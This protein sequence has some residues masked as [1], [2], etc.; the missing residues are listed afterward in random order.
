[1]NLKNWLTLT[2]RV[3]DFNLVALQPDLIAK[4]RELTAA[5]HSGLNFELTRM[6]KDVETRQV[7]CKILLA[8][9]WRELVGWAL[10]S[11]ENTDYCF[12]SSV[13]GFKAEDGQMFQVFIHPDYRRQGIGSELYKKA[14]KLLEGDV[15]C[16]CPWDQKSYNLFNKFPNVIRKEL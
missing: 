1:M 15:I 3:L 2:I 11:K 7:N 14:V 12:S 5:P 13:T 8:Y 16:V 6:L 10:L 4:L 9:R